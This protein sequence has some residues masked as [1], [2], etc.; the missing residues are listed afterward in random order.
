M[1]DWTP[2]TFDLILRR[3]NPVVPFVCASVP[4]TTRKHA[5]VASTALLKRH[6]ARCLSL[7]ARMG[8]G[9]WPAPTWNT[10][11]EVRRLNHR[12]TTPTPDTTPAATLL[13]RLV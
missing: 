9:Q 10:L 8:C 5:P 7:E 4:G 2:P 1:G 3:V 6:P 13:A 12:L 11:I